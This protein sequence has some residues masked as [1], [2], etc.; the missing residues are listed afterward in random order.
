MVDEPNRTRKEGNAVA[1]AFT[2]I[3]V[4]GVFLLRNLDLLPMDS[5]WWAVLLLV[6]MFFLGTRI[7]ELRARHGGGLPAEA[8]GL[9]T[10][11]L[12]IAMVMLIFL[13]E[14]DWGDV[15]P[16]FIILIGV[17]FLFGSARSAGGAP[18]PPPPPPP[19]SSG[20]PIP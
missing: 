15:W 5:N 6:P 14:L 10:G 8:R 20:G 18:G 13:L 4:G 7:R 2:L 16:L 17:S 19:G 9:L 12:S 11:F 3:I 1:T